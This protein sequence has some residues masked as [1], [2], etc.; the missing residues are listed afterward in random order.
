M[1]DVS[2][3][4]CGEAGLLSLFLGNISNSQPLLQTFPIC[5]LVTIAPH[6][7]T[8]GALGLSPSETW[9]SHLFTCKMK[10]KDMQPTSIGRLLCAQH[11]AKHLHR[12]IPETSLTS[13]TIIVTTMTRKRAHREVKQCAHSPFKVSAGTSDDTSN[14]RVFGQHYGSKLLGQVT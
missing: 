12:S 7:L 11:C 5:P 13:C 1:P 6:M 10:V 3:L 2:Q 14:T 4:E 9:A 8:Q